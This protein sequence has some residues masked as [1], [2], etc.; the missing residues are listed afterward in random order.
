MCGSCFDLNALYVILIWNSSHITFSVGAF[1]SLSR[2]IRPTNCDPV[3]SY[4]KQDGV[5]CCV[6]HQIHLDQL[7]FYLYLGNKSIYASGCS[8][9]DVDI[10]VFI[11]R[12]QKH[13]RCLSKRN[14]MLHVSR[15]KLIIP[16]LLARSDVKH[17]LKYLLEPNGESSGSQWGQ[18]VDNHGT[19]TLMSFWWFAQL[20]PETF[21]R[22][23]VN[24]YI[25]IYID[26]FV[27]T[28]TQIQAPN[29]T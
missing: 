14:Q 12:Y 28:V 26:M 29:F 25:K 21:P 27:V 5:R 1:R 20:S 16:T 19:I 13:L 6:L 9:L 4:L 24:L 18:F 11:N 22:E 2:S 3:Y 10:R 7:P 15:H 17:C 8:T 23:N